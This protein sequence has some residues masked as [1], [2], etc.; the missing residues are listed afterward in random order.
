MNKFM[1]DSYIIGPFA[2]WYW[3]KITASPLENGQRDLRAGGRP[4]FDLSSS[5]P[6]RCYEGKHSNLSLGDLLLIS[7]FFTQV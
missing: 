5:S 6:R 1:P 7:V 4:I 3:V 2:E